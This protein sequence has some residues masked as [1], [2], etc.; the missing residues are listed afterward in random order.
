MKS[1]RT[2]K[3]PKPRRQPAWRSYPDT[4]IHSFDS[5][6]NAES[7]RP[8]ESTIMGCIDG[9]DRS[10]AILESWNP[11]LSLQSLIHLEAAHV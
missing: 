6:P 10:S 7:L 8:G 5:L 4:L 3:L 1:P 9:S 11:A 2:T